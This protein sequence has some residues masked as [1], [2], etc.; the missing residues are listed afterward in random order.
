MSATAMPT[1]GAEP[2]PA[3]SRP[4]R[5]RLLVAAIAVS[6]SAV[7]LPGPAQAHQTSGGGGGGGGA[8]GLI[9]ESR[10]ANGRSGLAYDG[11]LQAVAQAQ[12]DRMAAAG[13]IWHTSNLGGKLSWGWWAWA[14][15]VGYGAS[16]GSVH[17]AFMNS[18]YHAANI[19][20]RD[21]NYV[22]VGV[23]YGADGMVYVAQVFGAW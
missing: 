19:L 18:G 17:A 9:N 8:I 21:F 4:L 7:T 3:G 11:E 14:E 5:A 13:S 15:N 12:A 2:R 10:G 23:A 1:A 16:V 22:G 20:D 6:L